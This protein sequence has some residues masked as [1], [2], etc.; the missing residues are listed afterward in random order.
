[1]L[2]DAGNDSSDEEADSITDTM[3]LQRAYRS[4][5]RLYRNRDTLYVAG[6]IDLA[7]VYDDWIKIPFHQ[8]P[9]IHRY[10]VAD[11]YLDSQEG[12]GI[13]R[14]VGHSLGAV[15]AEEL[16]RRRNIPVTQYGSPTFDPIPRNPFHRPDRTACRFDPVAILDFGARKV[17]CLGRANQHNYSGLEN[18]RKPTY[19]KR[20]TFF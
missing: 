11:K 7:D 6:T 14:L 20:F 19:F 16:G 1:M 13:K 2:T 15:T 5:N 9:N 12:Q 10:K 4:A 8:V 18:F 3:G 17:D